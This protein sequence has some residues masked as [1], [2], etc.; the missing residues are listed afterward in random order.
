VRITPQLAL[1]KFYREN[2]GILRDWGDFIVSTIK[3]QAK[4]LLKLEPQCR[5]KEWASARAKVSIKGYDRPVTQ[6]T[7]LVGVRF[8]VLLKEDLPAI[9]KLIEAS[10]DWSAIKSK[11]ADEIVFTKPK[12][13]DYLSHHY[14][15][16]PKGVMS[17]TSGKATGTHCC[18]VQIRTILQHA[19]AEVE[20]STAYK[21][22]GEVPSHAVRLFARSV[23]LMETTDD[24]FFQARKYIADL[25][26]PLEAFLAEA[27]S[28]YSIAVGLDQVGLT[29]VDRVAVAAFRNEIARSD[30]D[31]FASFLDGKPSVARRIK[32][33]QPN[34]GLF[35]Y[36]VVV[37]VYW[38][39]PQLEKDLISRWPLA[40]QLRE[41]EQVLSDLGIS[42]H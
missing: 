4:G 1:E 31:E 15:V 32:E 42:A 27:A 2:S 25:N 34:G 3:S 9:C 7:D 40:D 19:Y 30:L 18:E 6:M 39:A 20:H 29:Q 13:F 10:D 16:R 36:A 14:E 33:N 22:I 26:E 12:N 28:R 5:L 24:L 11:D 35:S 17:L 41:I 23:A 37:V 8:I 38:L 21:P